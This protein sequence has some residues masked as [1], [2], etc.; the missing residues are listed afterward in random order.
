MTTQD[1]SNNKERIIKKIKSQISLAT[2][3]NIK[4]VMVKMI[5][6]LPQ[7]DNEKATMANI[8]KLTIKA[9][10]SYIKNDKVSTSNQKNDFEIRREI[11]L[12]SELQSSLQY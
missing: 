10:L 9:T 5:A 7:F 8:D 6:M 4:S 11:K 2:Q 12:K 1:L 3:E